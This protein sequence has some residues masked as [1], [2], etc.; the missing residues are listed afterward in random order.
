MDSLLLK[1][2]ATLDVDILEIETE[3]PTFKY[4]FSDEGIFTYEFS[5]AALES[6]EGYPNIYACSC[7]G[8]T[9]ACPTNSKTSRP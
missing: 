6:I 7:G 9:S 8:C 1:K 4:E 2:N 5:D 3:N